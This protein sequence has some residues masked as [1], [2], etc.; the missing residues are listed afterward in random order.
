MKRIALFL[1]I[2]IF[3]CSTIFAE[4]V[5]PSTDRAYGALSSGYKNLDVRSLGMG[6]VGV[7]APSSA[8]SFWLNPA[9][10]GDK[11]V[12]V[13]LPSIGVSVYH[14]TAIFGAYDDKIFDKIF[15]GDIEVKELYDNEHIQ[16]IL[17][18]GYGKI[19]D[20]NAGVSF[21]VGGFGFGVAVQDSLLT[22][23]PG[24]ITSTNVINQLNAE[25]RLG[26]GFKL[27]F[28]D[29]LS[30]DMGLSLGFNYLVYNKAIGMDTVLDISDSD[31]GSDV[32]KKIPFMA[33]WA[34]PINIGLRLNMPLG[35]TVATAV[36]N[37]NGRYYM[38]T[39]DNY[40]DVLKSPFGGN[41]KFKLDTDVS[42]D[43][44]V[45]WTLDWSRLFNPTVEID[46]VDLWGLFADD[47]FSGRSFMNHLKIGAEI[48]TLWVLDIRGGLDSGYWTLGAGLD[49]YALR[50]EAAYY[51]HEFGDVA[52][53][54]G[55]D[56]L[57]IQF[58]IG[59]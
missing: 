5:S 7:A 59:W 40:E 39:F 25:I 17:S 30:L 38:K 16:K 24:Q 50:M 46:F 36:N 32:L 33:G 13:S 1:L 14:P 20:I 48:K 47:G 55:I 6:G 44:G 54:K 10:L 57:T 23:L 8:Q 28:S 51:W 12:Q 19:L 34:I 3:A 58:N 53:D 2:C 27:N 9:G 4:I 26:Y 29:S 52:G 43:L 49:F 11:K 15:D 56:G 31:D 22:Y 37:I 41:E 45:A 21:T 42:W 35:F 18:Y